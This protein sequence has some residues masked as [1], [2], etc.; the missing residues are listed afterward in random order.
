MPRSRYV[1]VAMVEVAEDGTLSVPLTRATD[2]EG[3]PVVDAEGNPVFLVPGERDISK[4]TGRIPFLR[5]GLVSRDNRN[6][7]VFSSYSLGTVFKTVKKFTEGAGRESYRR[8]TQAA[9][10][11][12]ACA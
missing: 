4:L 12:A 2:A 9:A 8:E 5:F 10:E 6:K 7:V 3:N 11:K 1:A